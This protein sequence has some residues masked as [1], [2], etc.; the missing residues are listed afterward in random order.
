M[1]ELESGH[2]NSWSG[3]L[4]RGGGGHVNDLGRRILRKEYARFGSHKRLKND[5]VT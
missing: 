3:N 2:K 1:G 5:F 4:K